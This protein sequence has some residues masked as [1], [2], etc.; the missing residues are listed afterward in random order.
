[1]ATSSNKACCHLHSWT[2]E[3]CL[4]LVPTTYLL[5]G[6]YSPCFLY[7][8]GIFLML[9]L[10]DCC[11]FSDAE[12]HARCWTL[13]KISS[14]FSFPGC[15][16]PTFVMARLIQTPKG[17]LGIWMRRTGH[18]FTSDVNP[19]T[20]VSDDLNNCT[21]WCSVQSQKVPRG[22]K[23]GV[24]WWVTHDFHPRVRIPLKTKRFVPYSFQIQVRNMQI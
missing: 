8:A 6:F 23:V 24:E 2:V 19:S 3:E 18:K 11:S 1:M 7:Q 9:S 21:M 16:I 20:S 5:F 17:T 14:L 12:P 22:E 4:A 13:Y 15:Q 10:F